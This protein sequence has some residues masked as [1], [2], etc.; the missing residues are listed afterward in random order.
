M[1]FKEGKQTDP[2]MYRNYE[3]RE[4]ENDSRGNGPSCTRKER[5]REEER[6]SKN[7]RRRKIEGERHTYLYVCGVFLF[8]FTSCLSFVRSSSRSPHLVVLYSSCTSAHGRVDGSSVRIWNEFTLETF[9]ENHQ[10]NGVGGAVETGFV[11]AD[12][13]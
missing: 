13:E 7:E 3:R 5:E 4:R 8:V 2:G 6:I 1:Q 9:G 11:R 12:D 10:W